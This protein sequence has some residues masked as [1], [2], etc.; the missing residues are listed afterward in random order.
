MLWD[1]I[2][3]NTLITEPEW[4]CRLTQTAQ[5][6]YVTYETV[7][8]LAPMHYNH[9][10]KSSTMQ[11]SLFRLSWNRVSRGGWGCEGCVI[12]PTVRERDGMVL[13]ELLYPGPN[14]GKMVDGQRAKKNRSELWPNVRVE[15]ESHSSAS[16]THEPLCQIGP[17]RWQ[18][19]C[20]KWHLRHGVGI[21]L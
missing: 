8:L 21:T 9:P 10:V 16:I 20:L 6:G 1:L 5:W 18:P 3:R 12:L 14:G 7:F 2:W 11:K 4:K 17:L 13:W 19:W 15:A